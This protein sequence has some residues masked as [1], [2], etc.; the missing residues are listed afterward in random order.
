MIKYNGKDITPK[1]NGVNVNR[2]MY[3]GKQIYPDNTKG[4]NPSAASNGVYVYANDDSAVD[5]H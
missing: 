3:N 5:S 4:I 1:Y 2:V